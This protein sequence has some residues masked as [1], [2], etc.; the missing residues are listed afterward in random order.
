[1]TLI[2]PWQTVCRDLRWSHSQ[3]SWAGWRDEWTAWRVLESITSSCQVQQHVEE[4]CKVICRVVVKLNNALDWWLH[5]C[6]S[7]RA[8][9]HELREFTAVFLQS[10]ETR[11][12]G[13]TH[14]WRAQ[15]SFRTDTQVQ[16][17]QERLDRSHLVWTFIKRHNGVMTIDTCIGRREGRVHSECVW[18]PHEK[19]LKENYW[20]RLRPQSVK[21][22]F[23]TYSTTYRLGQT[24]S[25][26]CRFWDR[27]LGSRLKSPYMFWIVS[28]VTWRKRWIFQ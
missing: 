25:T 8:G 9:I 12:D 11:D 10:R 21:N 6:T 26:M 4:H 3:D 15:Y 16:K 23:D 1:M 2:G 28:L 20:I 18:T 22:V 19:K 24:Y 14:D 5:I 17:V 13:D 7:A 27:Y